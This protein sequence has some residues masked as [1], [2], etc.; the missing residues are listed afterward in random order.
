MDIPN[1]SDILKTHEKFLSF[2]LITL[3]K[4]IL[5]PCL[6]RTR[7]PIRKN[8]ISRKFHG[9]LRFH[10]NYRQETLRKYHLP[11]NYRY[12]NQDR[13]AIRTLCHGWPQLEVSKQRRNLTRFYHGSSDLYSEW[14][15][16]RTSS[17]F[18]PVRV[19]VCVIIFLQPGNYD[20][21]CP[22]IYTGRVPKGA[23]EIYRYISHFI[24]SRYENCNGRS[25][26]E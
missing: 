17:N 6:A 9:F 26:F 12:N 13:T 11:S 20:L 10:A 15:L 5:I 1:I 8:F 16:S 4:E 25:S 22:R 3:I 23:Y 2:L 19:T 7:F 14:M 18:Y 21:H 24:I